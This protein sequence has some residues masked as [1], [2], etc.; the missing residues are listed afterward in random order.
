MM[1]VDYTQTSQGF[2]G[3]LSVGVWEAKA[4]GGD[5][6]GFHVRI[7]GAFSHEDHQVA[8]KGAPGVV[9]PVNVLRWIHNSKAFWT[10]QQQLRE[11]RL[12]GADSA[13]PLVVVS[14]LKLGKGQR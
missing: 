4:N 9:L 1:L 2:S 13:T 7:A 14:H 3:G 8:P 11:A 12:C 5:E 10:E 6:S